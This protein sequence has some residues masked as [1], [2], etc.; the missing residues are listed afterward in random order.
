MVR[1]SG[2][3]ARPGAQVLDE[4][5]SRDR[6]GVEVPNGDEA[7]RPGPGVRERHQPHAERTFRA[8]LQVERHD[9]DTEPPHHQRDDRLERADPGPDGAGGAGLAGRILEDMGDST[10]AA[11]L[12][13]VV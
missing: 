7:A 1:P 11:E 12:D 10:V 4:R 6:E 5:L 8:L 13:L 2:Q 9:A 3:W